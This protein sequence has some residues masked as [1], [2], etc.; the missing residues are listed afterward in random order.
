MNRGVLDAS[1]P[2]RLMIR[3]NTGSYIS[4]LW[5]LLTQP[6]RSTCRRRRT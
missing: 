2:T 6:E 1:T 5:P 4:P 3:A